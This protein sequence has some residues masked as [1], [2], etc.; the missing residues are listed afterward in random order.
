[1]G[2]LEKNATR[3]NTIFQGF[4]DHSQEVYRT[5][6]LTAV[7]TRDRDSIFF[8]ASDLLI[9]AATRFASRN[10]A[11][12]IVEPEP[13]SQPPSAPAL[14][15]ARITSNSGGSSFCRCGWWNVS[16]KVPRNLA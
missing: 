10:V 4:F 2:T 9:A 5:P 1:M 14:S 6:W 13:L 7:S 12:M 15:P 16:S 11:Q 3:K 8:C